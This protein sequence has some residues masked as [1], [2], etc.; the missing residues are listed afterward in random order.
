MT[1]V[2]LFLVADLVSF[3]FHLMSNRASP[4][5]AMGYSNLYPHPPLLRNL[6]FFDPSHGISNSIFTP[7]HGISTQVNH[8]PMEFLT[9][10][11]S[12]PWNFQYYLPPSHGISSILEVFLTPP[13]NFQ[14]KNASLHGI[15]HLEKN[16]LPPWNFPVP[17]QG[18][19]ADINWNSP[20]RKG[21]YRF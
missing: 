20:I 2:L 12:L 13:W 9:L 4:P 1:I 16:A 8:P 3:G 19:G 10:F 21:S 6:I 14:S 15:F 17:Q 5:Y 18:G 7:F 11:T